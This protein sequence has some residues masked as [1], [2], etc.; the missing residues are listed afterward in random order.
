MTSSTLN[1]KDNTKRELNHF[2]PNKLT[3]YSIN[4]ANSNLSETLNKEARQL[5]FLGQAVK[6]ITKRSRKT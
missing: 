6:S 1:I 5:T 2:K 4:I 3:E